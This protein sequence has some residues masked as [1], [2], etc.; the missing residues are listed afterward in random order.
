[1]SSYSLD[2]LLPV[3]KPRKAC[4]DLSMLLAGSFREYPFLLLKEIFHHRRET[5][6]LEIKSAQQSG[7]FYV[8]NG[9]I[10][11]GEVGKLRGA[12]AVEVVGHLPDA[13]FQFKSLEPTDYARVVWERSFGSS[14]TVA[15]TPSIRSEVFRTR[16]AQVLS[17]AEAANEILQLVLLSLAQGAARQVRLYAPVASSCVKKVSGATWRQTRNASSI[18]YQLLKRAQRKLLLAL[19]RV[20]SRRPVARG[21]VKPNFKYSYPSHQLSVPASPGPIQKS[22]QSL[23]SLHGLTQ[24]NVFL[25]FV[26]IAVFYGTLVAGF[27]FFPLPEDRLDIVPGPEQNVGTQSTSQRRQPSTKR[28]KRKRRSSNR[29]P[30]KKSD[31]SRV[32]R[33][34]FL[35]EKGAGQS[36]TN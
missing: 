17:Y 21:C 6:L 14:E 10:K 12:K 4:G 35:P 36:P 34:K 22:E 31:E 15:A 24:S 11:D 19:K 7:Y 3:E 23:P 18:A 32:E 27:Y 20:M 2:G 26:S 29:I 16:L 25:V 9:E 33:G 5:G 1:V 30:Q 8:K 28:A 13:S